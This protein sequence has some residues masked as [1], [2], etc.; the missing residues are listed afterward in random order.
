MN[1]N[2]CVASTSSN[3]AKD[4]TTG[5]ETQSPAATASY[6]AQSLAATTSNVAVGDGDR[7]PAALSFEATTTGRNVT[8][9]L[10]A[11]SGNKTQ[12]LADTASYVAQSLAATTSNVAVDDSDRKLEAVSFEAI[13]GNVIQSPAA[14]AINVAQLLAASTSDIAQSNLAIARDVAQ[15]L[16]ATASHVAQSSVAAAGNTNAYLANFSPEMIAEDD[17]AREMLLEQP[18]YFPH[19]IETLLSTFHPIISLQLL[20]ILPFIPRWLQMMRW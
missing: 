6:V 13:A 11:T 5:N 2:H 20:T 17:A 18:P 14:T 4:N 16:I 10:E 8:Q 19:V 1:M 3:M 12:S 15:S 7:K 9:I